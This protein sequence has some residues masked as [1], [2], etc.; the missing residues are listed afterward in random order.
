MNEH[1][2]NNLKFLMNATSDQLA[3]WILEVEE[4]DISYAFELFNR[5]S[6]EIETEALAM[7]DDVT[8]LRQAKKVIK[9]IMEK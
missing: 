3:K 6:A 2:A 7:L 5:A 8:D 1:D 4:D 9:M